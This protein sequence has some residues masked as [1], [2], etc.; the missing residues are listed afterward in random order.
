MLSKNKIKLIHSLSR[1]KGR[2]ETG[3]FVAEGNKIGLELLQKDYEIEFLAAT[4]SWL[5]K[6]ADN[7]KKKYSIIETDAASIKKISNQV[8]PSEILVVARIPETRVDFS[9]AEKDLCLLLDQVQDPGNM[10]TIIR[11]AAWFG[12]SGIFCTDNC[13]DLYNPK[14]VQASMGAFTNVNIN[15]LSIDHL[16]N[17]ILAKKQLNVYGTF[18]E[19]EN[20]YEATLSKNGLI[21]MG[22]ESKGISTELS[23]SIKTRIM[24]P[25]HARTEQSIDS[26]NVAIATALV[27]GE[28]RRRTSK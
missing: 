24:I 20:I 7:L 25:A 1:K 27:C 9:L 12:I 16:L 22:N 28:F 26:L 8:T 6:N 4:D 15:Y 13:T 17:Y 21:V 19:G 11:I 5:K 18:L 2:N 3:L 10:G 14:V 23:Q